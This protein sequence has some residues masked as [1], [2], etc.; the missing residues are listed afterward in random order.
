MTQEELLLLQKSLDEF[1]TLTSSN[2]EGI[3]L[4][5]P[6]KYSKYLA[7]YLEELE[8]YKNLLA[9]KEK[10]FGQ[11]FHHFKFEVDFKLDTLR[12]IEAKISSDDRFNALL[13]SINYQEKVIKFLEK[14]L[15]NL[16]NIPFTVKNFIEIM[17]FKN[18][19]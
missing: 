3:S 17:K 12:E 7:V 16:K 18:G 1:L 19:C 11:L 2:A 10:L 13:K 14:S 4:K 5:M 6:L 15:E 9:D 8:V